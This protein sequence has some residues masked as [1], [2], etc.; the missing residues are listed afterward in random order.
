MTPGTRPPGTRPARAGG[1]APQQGVEPM[2]HDTDRIDRLEMRV[3]EQERVIEDLDATVTAQ[4]TAIDQLR[5]QLGQFVDR[6]ADA[7]RRLPA[8]PDAPP[9]HY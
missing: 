1:R 8:E 3:A 7:E 6:L 2:S 9:P 5:R 4:W